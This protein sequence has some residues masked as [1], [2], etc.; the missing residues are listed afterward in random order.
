[1][2]TGRTP[3]GPELWPPVFI[4]RT[5]RLGEQAW[6]GSALSPAGVGVW[7]ASSWQAGCPSPPRTSPHRA[8]STLST[9]LPGPAQGRQPGSFRQWSPTWHA[10]ITGGALKPLVQGP[11]RV[12][13]MHVVW[14]GAREWQFPEHH[15]RSGCA[16]QCEDPR[17]GM[18][19]LV[20]GTE[21]E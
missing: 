3:A 16:A 12:C 20:G 15:R 18:A 13:L 6:P 9:L 5:R 4:W 8:D 19:G 7:R 14:D 11:G 1:M 10:R 2:L 21:A 17:S